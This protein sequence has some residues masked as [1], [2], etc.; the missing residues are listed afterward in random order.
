MSN[1]KWIVYALHILGLPPM[2]MRENVGVSMRSLSAADT[3]SICRAY[4]F[5]T[6]LGSKVRV[7]YM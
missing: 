4:L 5:M 3:G 2:L 1:G 7:S 6:M